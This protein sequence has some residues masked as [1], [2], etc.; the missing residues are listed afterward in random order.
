MPIK[1]THAFLAVAIQLA[2]TP[3]ALATPAEAS[4]ATA[5]TTQRSTSDDAFTLGRVDVR[6]QVLPTAGESTLAREQLDQL[7]AKVLG[8]AISQLPGT[9]LSRN[10]RNEATISVHGFDPRQVPVFLDGIPQYVPY[11]GY[12]DFD[13]F[14]TFDLA[15]IRVATGGASLLYGPNTLGGAINLV[16]RRPTEALQGDVRMGVGSSAEQTLAANIGMRQGAWYLQAGA[17]QLQADGFPLPKGFVD[18]KSTP[19]DTGDER[20][21]AYRDDRRYSLKIGYAPSED[22][23]YAVGYVRQNGEKGNPVYAGRGRSGIRYWRWPWWDKESLYLIANQGL[24]DAHSLKLRAYEDRYGNGLQAYTDGSYATELN[25]TSFPSTYADRTQ[26][27][28]AILAS[29]AITHHLVQMS[30][31]Y[32]ADQHRDENPKSPTKRYRDVTTSIAIEDAIQIGTDWQLKL[33]AS[34]E[35]REAREVYQWP[36]GSTDATNGLV[37]LLRDVGD[38]GELVLTASHKTRFPT[39]KDRYSARM[40]RALPNPDLKPERAQH[41]ELGWRGRLWN[42]AAASVSVYQSR[43]DDLIQD[44]IVASDQCGGSECDQAQNI[45]RARHR[46]F[47]L[48]LDQRLGDWLELGVAYT[49]LDRDNL[50]DPVTR[51]TNTPRQRVSAHA[52]WNFGA[53]WYLVT[54]AEAEQGRIVS[55]SAPGNQNGYLD[56]PGFTVWGAKLVYEPTPQWQLDVGGRNLSDHW[57]ELAEGYPMPGRTWFANVAYRF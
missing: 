39:I 43:I 50:S 42:D 35:R 40:G 25:T 12:I 9:S 23:E 55:T 37:E 22:S 46:G 18:Y 21:N 3:T 36:L 32:K 11:D 20:E 14:T 49:L 19:T 27:A 2:L 30:V 4:K 17:S 45:G 8:D 26:G 52:R 7:D 51:L 53:H 41:L 57:Y 28:S 10:S 16:S 33:G 48:A 56:L 5:K 47:D 1:P 38:A 54:T 15:E 31:S 24:G 44:A 6:A 13:R 29:Q 34:H